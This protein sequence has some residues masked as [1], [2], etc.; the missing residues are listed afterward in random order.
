MTLLDR[1]PTIVMCADISWVAI[2]PEV[3][4]H[5]DPEL[6]QYISQ[7]ILQ[8]LGSVAYK[9]VE[10]QNAVSDKFLENPDVLEHSSAGS[11]IGEA[12]YMLLRAEQ[13]LNYQGIYVRED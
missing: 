4:H 5:Y 11:Q 2:R 3:Q 10:L 9:A 8:V 12:F 7:D 13:M 1:E 6:T